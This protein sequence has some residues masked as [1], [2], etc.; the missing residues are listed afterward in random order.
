MKKR[1]RRE[2]KFGSP[3]TTTQAASLVHVSPSTILRAVQMKKLR[4]FKTPGGHSRLDSGAVIR[5]FQ[6]SGPE[7]LSVAQMEE[8]LNE[9]D[10]LF[11]MQRRR[12]SEAAGH[13]RKATRETCTPDLG[14][15]VA[16][17][18]D[19]ARLPYKKTGLGK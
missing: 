10:H 18:M 5:L 16:W 1:G 3:M 13:W 11:E 8:K 17:L 14:Q 7:H 9:Y 12:V 2:Y 6:E 15:L 19:K 4:A